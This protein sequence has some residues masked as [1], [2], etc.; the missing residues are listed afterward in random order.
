MTMKPILICRAKLER[1]MDERYK[2]KEEEIEARAAMMQK[3]LDERE[4]MIRAQAAALEDKQKEA[5]KDV[6]R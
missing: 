4:E 5:E 1:D 2:G 6:K 3:N